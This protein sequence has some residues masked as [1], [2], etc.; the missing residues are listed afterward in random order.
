MFTFF[1][2]FIR[3]FFFFF[4][5][6]PHTL[7]ILNTSVLLVFRLLGVLSVATDECFGSE[8]AC[9]LWS[10]VGVCID[11]GGCLCNLEC[12]LLYVCACVYICVCVCVCVCVCE[13]CVFA[14]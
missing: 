13:L 2:S 5:S 9:T 11:V 7:L 6:L 14:V 3:F 12:S 8:C 1:L 4:W 10:F